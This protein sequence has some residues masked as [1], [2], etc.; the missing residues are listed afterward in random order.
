MDPTA[1]ANLLI[2]LGSM[3]VLGAFWFLFLGITGGNAVQIAAGVIAIAGA[4]G[5]FRAYA[6]T[7]KD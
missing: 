3:L 6:A 4:V 5:V 2:F 7:R 1:K